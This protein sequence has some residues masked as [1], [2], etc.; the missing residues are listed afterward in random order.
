MLYGMRFLY[1]LLV[2]WSQNRP[3]HLNVN[4]EPNYFFVNYCIIYKIN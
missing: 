2:V 1:H 4:W 3:K